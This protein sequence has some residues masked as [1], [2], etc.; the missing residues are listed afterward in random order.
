MLNKTPI[1]PII[2]D[3]KNNQFAVLFHII[4]DEINTKIST[5]H[6]IIINV[7]PILSFNE[8]LLP[9]NNIPLTYIILQKR[10]KSM[11]LIS[12]WYAHKYDF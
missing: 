11:L 12:A 10:N 8:F 5:P 3:A 9:I 6:N 2:P 4:I 1:E 7:L